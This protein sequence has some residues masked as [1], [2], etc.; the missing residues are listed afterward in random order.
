MAS[1]V[2]SV[3]TL[4][5]NFLCMAIS[6]WFAIYI[7]ARSHLNHLTF[8]AVVALIA[9]VFFYNAAFT[10]MVN[11]ASNTDAVRSFAIIIALIAT[12]DLTH[13]LLPPTERRKLY[14][15]A[16]G[17]VL[18]AVITILLLFTVS[19]GDHCDPRYSCPAD[20][21]FPWLVIDTFKVL[22][23][24]AI[25]YNLWLIKKSAGR[26]QNVV[27]YEA[28]LIAASTMAYGLIATIFNLSLARFIPNMLML[29]ALLLLAYSVMR[30][31]TFLTR[32]TSVY[33]MPLTLATIAVIVGI[34]ILAAGQFELST[35]EML[36]LAV[37]AIFTHSSYDI[38]REFLDRLFH[39]Q[40]RRMLRELRDLGRKPSKESYLPRFLSR[41]LAILCQS[42]QTSG[43][44]VALRKGDDYHVVAS[45]HSLP[46]GTQLPHG[47]ANLE[48]I[49]QPPR[50]VLAQIAWLAPA[51]A[52]GEQVA[53][54]GMGARKDKMTFDDEDLYWLEDV[55]DEIGWMVGLSERRGA[56]SVKEP[57]EHISEAIPLPYPMIETDELLSTLAYKLDPELVKNVEEGYRN[58]YDYSKLGESPLVTLFGIR[59]ED[60][61]ERGKLVQE[62][63]NNILEKLRPA[64]KTPSE[65]LPREWYA[66]TILH[67]AYVEGELARD[68]MA[69]L[70][71]SEGTY[72]RT[73]RM[74]LRGITR[75]LLEMGN[76]A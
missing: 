70:Y 38:V 64:G 35:T 39:R 22:V 44:F 43:G 20:T 67:S 53:V 51:Y 12:H 60:H 16:R 57:V 48:Q 10:E 1:D 8:R 42:L 73:R 55:A 56:T 59:A 36:M 71:I 11:P 75:A 30:D 2:L 37:L 66:Y 4:L 15:L 49:S 21:S 74:A 76:V 6:L 13:Y 68:I 33:D 72:F 18:F 17:I 54:I 26:L 31:Q 27:F 69:K 65:P 23:F 25:L 3:L 63:L 50:N 46:V 19:T 32:R 14:W 47:V 24:A 28:V 40:E 58:L 7:L 41:G 5:T 45:L 61:I 52:A 62:R 29:A 9:L 34:Y